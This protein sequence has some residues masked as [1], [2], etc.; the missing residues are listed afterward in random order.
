M[1]IQIVLML[2]PVA[3]SASLA[4]HTVAEALRNRP[5]HT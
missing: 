5:G 2:P 3:A 4:R 1:S